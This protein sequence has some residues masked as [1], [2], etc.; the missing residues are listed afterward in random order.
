MK[1]AFLYHNIIYQGQQVLDRTALIIS[2][3]K[4]SAV[5][6]SHLFVV[7]L[8]LFSTSTIVSLI[9]YDSCVGYL[10]KILNEA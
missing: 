4:Q 1:L 5:P 3:Y 2:E 9:N 8:L 6:V 10:L 7:F